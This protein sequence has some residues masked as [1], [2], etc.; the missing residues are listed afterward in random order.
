MTE[1]SQ[2]NTQLKTGAISKAEVTIM[3][4]CAAAPAMCIGGSMGLLA[5]QTGRGISLSA[6]IAT[7]A[8][9]LIGLSYG[10]L[11]EKYNRCG[12][13]WSYI[14]QAIGMKAGLWTAFVYF[15]V[16]LT[17]S[18]CPASIFSIYLNYLVPAIPMWLCWFIV[19]VPVCFITWWGIELSTKILIVVWL[20]QMVLLVWPAI[21]IIAMAPEGFSFGYSMTNS[22]TPDFGIIGL[23]LAA[24]TWVWAY[25]GFECPAYMGEELKGGSKAV[26]FAIPISALC[27]GVIYIIACWLW[28]ATMSA[29]QL[30]ATAGSGTFLA[31]YAALVGYVAGD[32]LVAIATIVSA[33]ACAQA[34]YSLMP[35]FLFDL[36]RAGVLPKGLAKVNKHQIP[37]VGMFTYGAISF[38]ASLYA[39]Y[40]YSAN[41]VFNGINDWFII[42]GM[43]ACIAYGF[44]CIANIK[45]GWKDNSG[46]AVLLRKI[47]PM[48]TTLLLAYMV[49]TTLYTPLY[50]IVFAFFVLG[51][52]VFALARKNA[53][54]A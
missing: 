13:T 44:I 17:T 41:G 34:F 37:H 54:K 50:I 49:F 43:T 27:V 26:K 35:R 33:V 30:A 53:V 51:G 45:D 19:I 20:V 48:I 8:V 5:A 31:D 52:I 47:V 9:V 38:L 23:G 2:E 40:G 46:S 4:I 29:D 39:M 6:V 10:K 7:L 3:S 24:V 15:G 28:M 11:S 14:Q 18:A 21:K 1:Y 32:K 16:L 36:G 12:G 25:V 22:F 42:M